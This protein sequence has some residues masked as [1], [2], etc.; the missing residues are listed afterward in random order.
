[1]IKNWHFEIEE[2]NW[3]LKYATVVLSVCLTRTVI[4]YRRIDLVS[5]CFV[6]IYDSYFGLGSRICFWGQECTVKPFVVFFFF[7]QILIAML[8]KL[9]GLY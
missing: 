1:M 3:T 5:T 8:S 7:S 9:L 4:A 6:L 2:V